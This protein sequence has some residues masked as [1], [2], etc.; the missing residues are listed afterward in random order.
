MLSS[1]LGSPSNGSAHPNGEWL[2]KWGKEIFDMKVKQ[3][4]S[5]CFRPSNLFRM[6]FVVAENITLDPGYIG[7]FGERE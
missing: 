2:K 7:F 1:L 5:G 6:T 4:V 3:K